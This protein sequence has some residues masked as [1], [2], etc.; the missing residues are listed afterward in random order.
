V[1]VCVYITTHSLESRYTLQNSSKRIRDCS[2]GA[3]Q[4]PPRTSSQGLFTVP[5]LL[6]KIA[7]DALAD[8]RLNMHP[9]DPAF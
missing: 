7:Q 1:C 6:P 5:N 2:Q 9:S 3:V 4:Q 8:G